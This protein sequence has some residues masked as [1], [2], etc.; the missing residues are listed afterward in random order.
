MP[1]GGIRAL[2]RARFLAQELARAKRLEE[3]AKALAELVGEKEVAGQPLLKTD[4]ED[5]LMQ[6]GLKRQDARDLFKAKL[7]KLWRTESLPAGKGKGNPVGV[8]TVLSI[9]AWAS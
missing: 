5:Y 8:F 6:Q 3:A 4:A 9:Q 7:G 2:K 1:R